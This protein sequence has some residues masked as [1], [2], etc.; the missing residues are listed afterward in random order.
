M[1]LS[2]APSLLTVAFGLPHT[3]EQ[4]PQRAVHAALAIQHLLAEAR[5]AGEQGP[6][7]EVR[8]AVH[9]GPMLVDVQ[10]RDPTEWALAV[11][12]TLALQ[13]RLLGQAAPE[14]I[15]LSPRVGRMVEGWF[16]LQPRDLPGAGGTREQVGVYV[17]V[18]L[19]LQRTPL[20]VYEG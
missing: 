3:L 5:T 16:A 4:L 1:L 13:V 14:E 9:L 7:P 15:V 10:A 11:G 20:A 18:G 19:R 12:E 6:C 2:H 8:Q 17:V